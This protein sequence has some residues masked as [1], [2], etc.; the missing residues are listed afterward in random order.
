MIQVDYE[1]LSPS[2]TFNLTL[3]YTNPDNPSDTTWGDLGICAGP[4][5][6]FPA[7]DC[8]GGL[9]VLRN[10]AT[11]ECTEDSD[12]KWTVKVKLNKGSFD[13][14]IDYPSN[15][16]GDATSAI[17]EIRRYYPIGYHEVTWTVED[18]CGNRVSCTQPFHV[19]FN[20]KPTLEEII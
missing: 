17:F 9:V 6:P 18:L 16:V 2:S 3:T 11:D 15:N 7:D 13:E 19:E 5:E 1:T 10:S 14:T 8:N 12:L 20:K 4:S